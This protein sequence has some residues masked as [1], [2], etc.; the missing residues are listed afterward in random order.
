ME[1]VVVITIKAVE[2]GIEKWKH[3]ENNLTGNQW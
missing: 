3:L 1:T 2:I